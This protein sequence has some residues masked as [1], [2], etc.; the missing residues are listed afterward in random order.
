[1]FAIRHLFS[2]FFCAVSVLTLRYDP[3]HEGWNLNLN[4]TA[5]HPLDYW[6]E[7]EDH[8]F[9]PSPKNWRVPF[10]VLTLDRYVDGDPTNNE[11][12]GTSFEHDWTSNQFRF[13]GD[14]R[15]LMNNLDYIQGMGIK[16]IYL[17]GTPFINMPWSGDGFGALDF[18]LLDHHHVSFL[19]TIPLVA[20]ICSLHTEVSANVLRV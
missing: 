5:T 7:W 20:Q 11:A 3:A 16:A 15:G 4:Q 14:A 9:H 1:M 13:G 10:Y 6:G 18:T 12:N 2:V 17:S 19:S 8:K